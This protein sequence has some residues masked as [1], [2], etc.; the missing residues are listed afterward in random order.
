MSISRKEF[1][2]ACTL[3]TG[4]FFIK[5]SSL[6]GQLQ[7][8]KD[9]FI[10]LRD[11][12]GIYLE[13]GGTIAW[14]V[15]PDAVVVI[16]SQFP[17]TAKNFIA[18]LQKITTRKIDILFNTHHHADHTS[19]NVYLKDFTSKI[20]AHEN[21]VEF[22]KKAYGNDPAK[23]QVYADT[24]FKTSWSAAI[25]KEKIT[26]KYYGPGHTG[27][28]S[29]IHFENA[30]IVH[31]GDLVF[32]R[33]SPYIDLNGGGSILNWIN[34]LDSIAKYYPKETLYIFGHGITNE[35]V[36]GSVKDVLLMR[37]Y[38]SALKDLVSSGIKSGKTKEQIT[39]A[40]E[41]PGFKDIKEMRPGMRK[42][43]LE[44]TYDELSE[45]KN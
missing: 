10:T 34:V 9:G 27:G 35:F 5:S 16:D 1:L 2:K 45:N 21:C 26:A 20:V 8:K 17:D 43:S 12:Y 36:T 14:Y 25:G 23:P 28:D 33:I 42:M 30:N 29:V 19:G 38:L 44:R 40:D 7:E 3:F 13:R 22:Q 24:V 37:D 11:N 4:G 18:S 39:T 31:V 41:I 32:N 15:T 6:L